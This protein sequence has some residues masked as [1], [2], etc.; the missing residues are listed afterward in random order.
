[1]TEICFCIKALPISAC[2]HKI[3]THTPLFLTQKDI[4]STRGLQGNLSLAHALGHR[5]H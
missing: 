5:V 3:F 1:M 4:P 2:S